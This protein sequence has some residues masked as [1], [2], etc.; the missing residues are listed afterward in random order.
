[1]HKIGV[2]QMIQMNDEELQYFIEEVVQKLAA[3]QVQEDTAPKVNKENLPNNSIDSQ[4]EPREVTPVVK[5]NVPLTVRV[6]H[7]SQYI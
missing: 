2:I 6:E 1:M 7:T 5:A 3:P 4:D